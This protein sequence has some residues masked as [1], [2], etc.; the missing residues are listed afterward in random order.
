[1]VMLSH[2]RNLQIISIRCSSP[3]STHNRKRSLPVL[4][5]GKNEDI[6]SWNKK[7]IHGIFSF[8]KSTIAKRKTGVGKVNLAEGEVLFMKIYSQTHRDLF[9]KQVVFLW[10]YLALG[11]ISSMLIT[12]DLFL[13]DIISTVSI[14]VS[15]GI[16]NRVLHK[17]HTN[18]ILEIVLTHDNKVKVK[19]LTFYGG[20]K[21]IVKPIEDCSFSEL[22]EKLHFQ[23]KE[24]KL[25]W[26][27]SV[28][29][30][31][32]CELEKYT[33]YEIAMTHKKYISPIA[34]NSIDK[35]VS[36]KKLY[37]KQQYKLG[38]KS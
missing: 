32:E 28:M 33:A 24:F 31:K 37:L 16:V 5:K 23:G 9:A 22:K 21:T 34:N 35:I 12:S 6:I 8:I 3:L 38:I 4:N 2:V 26:R 25:P 27:K 18:Q 30:M 13:F 10:H 36:S 11:T 15:A 1:M 19:T 14:A 7:P 29:F 20:Y 17:R